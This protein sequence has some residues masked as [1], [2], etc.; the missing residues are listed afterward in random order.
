MVPQAK[1]PGRKPKLSI[2]AVEAALKECAGIYTAA[3]QMLKVDRTTVSRYVKRHERLQKVCDEAVDVTL[4]LCEVKIINKIK[5]DGDMSAIAFYMNNKGGHRGYGPRVR[6]EGHDGGA[7]KHEHGHNHKIDL[8]DLDAD[9]RTQ[10]RQILE[11]R[12]G[13]SERGIN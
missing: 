12:A 5:E 10:L 8:S 6:V 2:R 11:R 3:A 9:E 13:E 4:D 7:L 1:K